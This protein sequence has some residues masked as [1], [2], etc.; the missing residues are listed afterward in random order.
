MLSNPAITRGFQL[1]H[2][3]FGLVSNS[4]QNALAK[5][6]KFAVVLSVISQDPRFQ[7]FCKKIAEA[8]RLV[9][10]EL[11]KTATKS[12]S[13]AQSLKSFSMGLGVVSILIRSLGFLIRDVGL[14]FLRFG[15]RVTAVFKNLISTGGEVQATFSELQGLLALP[16]Q[17]TEGFKRLS[18]EIIR[19][20]ESSSK[21][22]SQVASLA[23]ELAR[24][25]FSAD[26]VTASIGSV[27]QLSEAAGVASE[28]AAAIAANIKTM[29]NL[30]ASELTRVNDVLTATANAST[31]SVESLG[32][33]FTYVGPLA[34]AFGFSLEEV[35]GAL[36]VLAN[37]GQKGS[38]AGAGLQ[39]MFSQLISHSDDV[40]AALKKYG[41]SFKDVN[42][43]IKSITEIMR[44]FDEVNLSTSDT[45]QIF[46][47]RARKTF[48][49][50]QAA[51]SD[52]LEQFIALNRESAGL[53]ARIAET[54]MDNLSG[55]ILRLKSAFE[56]VQVTIYQIIEDQ[57]RTFVQALTRMI[58]NIREFLS[59]NEKA[60]AGF[61]NFML[62]VAA[63]SFVLAGFTLALSQVVRAFGTF[64]AAAAT[65]AASASML[66]VT[67]TGI[68][69]M[70]KISLPSMAAVKTALIGMASSMNVFTVATNL[71]S[72]SF[73]AFWGAL[74]KTATFILATTLY[75]TGLIVIVGALAGVVAAVV[76]HWDKFS[77]ALTYFYNVVWLPI[78]TGF[79]HGFMEGYENYIK[80]VLD[81]LV[82]SF[83]DLSDTLSGLFGNGGQSYDTFKWF[84]NLVAWVFAGIVKSVE[85]TVNAFGFLIRRIQDIGRAWIWLRDTV[86]NAIIGVMDAPA[87]V[88]AGGTDFAMRD[89]A[90]SVSEYETKVKRLRVEFGAFVREHNKAMASFAAV[91]AG[92]DALVPSYEKA[93]GLLSRFTSLTANELAELQNEL[94][95]IKDFGG[96]FTTEGLTDK[97]KVLDDAILTMKVNLE[98]YRKTIDS[99]GFAAIT[100]RYG[101]EEA[102]NMKRT[103]EIAIEQTEKMIG[104]YQQKIGKMQNAKES[105]R[106][107]N[108]LTGTGSYTEFLAERD[109][110]KAA[111][112]Q[113]ATDIKATLDKLA[114]A[115]NTLTGFGHGKTEDQ[116]KD[117]VSTLN[118]EL[119]NLQN[120][121]T[122]LLTQ[123]SEISS[124][125]SEGHYKGIADGIKKHMG[126]G[127][128]L[129]TALT[130]AIGDYN[131]AQAAATQAAAD[132]ANAQEKMQEALKDTSE[133]LEKLERDIAL[134]GLDAQSQK[135]MQLKFDSGDTLAKL[136]EMEQSLRD[137]RKLA[138]E[139]LKVDPDDKDAQQRMSELDAQLAALGDTRKKFEDKTQQE[140]LDIQNDADSERVQEILDLEL[141][142][143]KQQ[144]DQAREV[145]LT[146][147]KFHAETAKV[148]EEKYTKNGQRLKEADEYELQR[149][150][151]L[152]EE[153]KAI[154]ER[155]AEE[156][157]KAA[158]DTDRKKPVDRAKEMVDIQNEAYQI[159]LKKVQSTKDLFA[160]ERALLKI[161][162]MQL[163]AALKMSSRAV[164]AET[165]VAKAQKLHD[166]ALANGM[167]PTKTGENLKR[168]QERASI[169]RGTSDLRNRQMGIGTTDVSALTV[170]RQAMDMTSNAVL[171]RIGDK[172]KVIGD[173]L[174][175]MTVTFSSIAE[176]WIDSFVQS[177]EKNSI[178]MEEAILATLNKFNLNLNTAALGNPL[179]P[180]IGGGSGA[181][182][183]L[184]A[185]GNS[186]VN[187]FQITALDPEEAGKR[188][189]RLINQSMRDS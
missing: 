68:L 136:A 17:D 185:N 162:E 94:K 86:T 153:L 33:S 98:N 115:S 120:K 118:Q 165:S 180:T 12:R 135:E 134:Y 147:Q 157:K 163:A 111:L 57:L 125:E 43:E 172:M 127:K 175:G 150:R 177:W 42:P 25:G 69:S 91:G 146:Q 83:F 97:I 55:D 30:Q 14:N 104:D 60:V 149:N 8:L 112:D 122:S 121:R 40:D 47:E 70:L 2:Q 24:A 131:K 108:I 82:Q 89:G 140:L 161:Q 126:T 159:L 21:T 11:Q 92:L 158:G 39:Q 166:E 26:E 71:A 10:G 20:G 78:Q 176:T 114:V 16:G 84:G 95:R 187:N 63:S 128:D 28:K 189:S 54:R 59:E 152:Q 4:A 113:T 61:A 116:I 154:N 9:Q 3:A 106:L 99:K 58:G 38:V 155:Y 103:M 139:K 46:S 144:K 133:T 132:W 142:L 119:E 129:I 41:K 186:I 7:E 96:E 184:N 67:Y 6:G 64:V 101:E 37:S 27:V 13:A 76:V 87:M 31:T 53:A 22:I 110:V 1:L 130:L 36:G 117:E 66:G 49:A 105:F 48:L 137:F 138:E 81:S 143:A 183:A 171:Q 188:I 34:S 102:S 79:I 65:M 50:L 124:I 107:I 73:S 77:E 52:T 90:E 141:D 164:R 29:F 170:A 62:T 174:N 18:D 15:Q 5:F 93:G 169:L 85:V 75:F 44:V 32:E 100:A 19:V 72:L 74:V 156:A 23:V 160:L 56:A 45:I 80:P 173:A 182:A 168:A 88:G 148:I 181:T 178:R 145:A 151:K 109:K 123:F 167:D 51:G 35:S 179:N